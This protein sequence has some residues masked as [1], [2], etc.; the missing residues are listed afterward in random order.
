MFDNIDEELAAYGM[1]S[2]E[3][4][5]ANLRASMIKAGFKKE[6]TEQIHPLTIDEELAA[7]GMLTEEEQIAD[8][9]ASMKKMN[10]ETEETK[11]EMNDY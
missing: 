7:F 11:D 10:I 2:E 5:L 4:Q 8:L 3:E 9:M 6:T 1:L